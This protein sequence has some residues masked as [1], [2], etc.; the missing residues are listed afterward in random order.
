MYLFNCLFLFIYL[1]IH[2]CIYPLCLQ[3]RTLDRVET[4]P[5]VHQLVRVIRAPAVD[6]VRERD[7]IGGRGQR[8][9]DERPRRTRDHC[10]T[11]TQTQTRV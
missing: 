7:V 9:G 3:F 2:S 5:V 4:Q 6:D 11:D 10:V 8:A 1:F